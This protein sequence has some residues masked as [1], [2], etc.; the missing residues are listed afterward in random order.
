MG[1]AFDGERAQFSRMIAGPRGLYIGGVLH[2]TFLEVDEEGTTA[3][4]V[5]GIQMKSLAMRR[6]SDEFNLVFDRPFVVVIADET[7]GTIL[8]LGIIGKP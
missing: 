6:P 4:A 3:A 8:F 1:I 2:R 7:N 5:T